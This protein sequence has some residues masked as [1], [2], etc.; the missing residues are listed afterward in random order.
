MSEATLE[1][2]A[3]GAIEFPPTERHDRKPM[4]LLS[5]HKAGSTIANRIL[6]TL[7]AQIGVPHIDMAGIAWQRGRKPDV[8]ILEHIGL[9]DRPGYYFGALRPPIVGQM[10]NFRGQRIVVQVRDP[11]DCVVSNFFSTAFGHVEPPAGETRDDFV[12]NRQILRNRLS[13]GRPVKQINKFALGSARNYAEHFESLRRIA[14]GHPDCFISKYEDMVLRTDAWIE[15]LAEFLQ[16]P[17]TPSYR[18]AVAPLLDFSADKEVQERL[19]RQ[20][21]PGDHVRKLQPETIAAITET[22]RTQLQAFGYPDRAEVPA[23]APAPARARAT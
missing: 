7:H 21:L 18:A 13:R 9:F 10:G 15:R 14:D 23:S 19:K 16:I 3:G 11:R 20:V 4:A 22:L 8:F 17:L 1:A 2:A 12:K 6:A 5:T